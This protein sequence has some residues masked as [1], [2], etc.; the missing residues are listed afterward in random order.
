MYLGFG[1]LHRVQEVQFPSWHF[2]CFVAIVPTFTKHIVHNHLE[3]R[4]NMFVNLA[5]ALSYCS[6]LSL[7]DY[8]QHVVGISNV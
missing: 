6:Q 4:Y 2:A 3:S 1:L 5:P 8:R 7:Y